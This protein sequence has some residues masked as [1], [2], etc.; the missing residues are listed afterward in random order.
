MAQEANAS[1]EELALARFEFE[2]SFCQFLK[3]PLQMGDMFLGHPGKDN[4][5]IKVKDTPVKMQLS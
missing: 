2:T 4:D 5:I 1:H 3:D